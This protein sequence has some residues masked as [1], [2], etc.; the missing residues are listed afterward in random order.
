MLEVAECCK[1]AGAM[2]CSL[3]LSVL[4]ARQGMDLSGLSEVLGQFQEGSSQTEI[5]ASG[6]RQAGTTGLCLNCQ[7]RTKQS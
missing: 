5:I 7:V 2:S 6:L 1:G 3:D 4:W